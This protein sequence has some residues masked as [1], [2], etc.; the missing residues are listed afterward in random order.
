MGKRAEKAK[1]MFLQGYNCT[2]AVLLAFSDLLGV[3]EATLKAVGL[4]MGG[5][6]VAFVPV[7]M[8]YRCV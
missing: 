8:P 1:E 2:Q 4:P 6:M 7:F 5:G 3:D